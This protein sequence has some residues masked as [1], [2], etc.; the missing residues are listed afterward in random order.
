M[1]HRATGEPES[2][3]VSFPDPDRMNLAAAGNWPLADSFSTDVS[4]PAQDQLFAKAIGFEYLPKGAAG[5][6]PRT[7]ANSQ[8]VVNQTEYATLAAESPWAVESFAMFFSMVSPDALRRIVCEDFPPCTGDLTPFLLYPPPPFIPSFYYPNFLTLTPQ[9]GLLWA[10]NKVQTKEVFKAQPAHVVASYNGHV[11]GLQ[12]R[13]SA[14][15]FQALKES[16]AACPSFEEGWPQP[17]EFEQEGWYPNTVRVSYDRESERFT[18]AFGRLQWRQSYKQKLDALTKMQTDLD[19][20]K[21]LME[22]LLS[23][24]PPNEI[25]INN[26]FA[27]MVR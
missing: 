2:I 27:N 12:P 23:S 16:A 17:R 20:L 6:G 21:S 7:H 13:I 8:V 4:S 10:A 24:P 26:E 14:D 3:G 19:N 15:M 22:G 1:K 11:T 9:Q 18:V 5:G 25:V